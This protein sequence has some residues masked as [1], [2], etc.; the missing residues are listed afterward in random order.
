MD[1]LSPVEH[2]PVVSYWSRGFYKIRSKRAFVFI[3]ACLEFVIGVWKKCSEAYILARAVR[4]SYMLLVLY[5]C[6]CFVRFA[7]VKSSSVIHS[8][9]MATGAISPVLIAIGIVVQINNSMADL[10]LSKFWT[11]NYYGQVLNEANLTNAVLSRT[12]LTRSDLGGATVEGADFSD[13]VIDLPQKLVH[14]C[15]YPSIIA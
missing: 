10:P 2:Y 8:L 5:A 9:M 14:I 1:T 15:F 12:V 13:A 6:I 3:C 4:H 7:N 11:L